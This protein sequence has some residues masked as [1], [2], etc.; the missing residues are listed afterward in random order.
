MVLRTFSG[1]LPEP[2]SYLSLTLLDTPVLLARDERGTLRAFVNA[3]A[4]RGA[5]VAHGQG[6]ARSLVCPFHGWAYTLDGQL[7]GR[8]EDDSFS[9]APEDCALR[10]L[11]VSERHGV[12]V[13]G[14]DPA[15]PQRTVDEALNE[16]GDEL[17]AFDFGDYRPLERRHFTVDANWKLVNDL[18]LES[19]HFRNLHR[20]SV[21]KVLHANAVVDTYGRHSRWAFPLQ[22][23]DALA[24]TPEE[25]WPDALQ[26]SLTF[27]LYPGVMFL[28]NSL[29]AQMIRA[30]DEITQTIIN[31]R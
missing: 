10:R 5:P 29:G 27:T 1:E 22:S 30:E 8:P 26:G 2:N 6:Q 3:C 24:D 14:L 20:D 13:V 19:Y 17:S 4:H 7:R 12:V 23:I 11:P 18:S 15:L 28:V 25:N 16:V 21:A 31:I 9:T